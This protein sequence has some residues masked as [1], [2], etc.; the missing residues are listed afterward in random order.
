[1]T[2]CTL[3]ERSLAERVEPR[4]EIEQRYARLGHTL[5]HGPFARFFERKIERPLLKFGLRAEENGP[6]QAEW[7]VAAQGES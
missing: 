3:E 1:M 6:A 5:R 4:I 7:I 2:N